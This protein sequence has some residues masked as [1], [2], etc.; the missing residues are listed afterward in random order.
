MTNDILS[1]L[2]K[3][4]SVFIV[5]LDMYAAFD[6]VDHQ[7]HLMRLENRVR[8]G[9]QVLDWVVSYLSSKYQY[10]SVAGSS[11][12]PKPLAC[13]F[14]QGSLLGPIFFTIYTLPLEDIAHQNN[15]LFHLYA[16]NTRL[17]LSFD[18]TDLAKTNVALHPLE[19]CTSEMK[20][21]ILTNK[22]KLN[23]GKTEFIE[24]SKT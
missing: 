24:I 21:W 11:Y 18:C 7:L 6:T 16:D 9:G 23:E 14:P 10:V 20:S 2:D 19:K 15:L 12:E 3:R 8:P 17:Y 5:L 1:S 22:L 4:N 13:G